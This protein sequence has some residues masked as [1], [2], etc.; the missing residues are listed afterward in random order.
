MLIINVFGC[1]RR[2]LDSQINYNK[3]E[4]CSEWSMFCVV[5]KNITWLIINNYLK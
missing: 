5:Y 4:K 1:T 2:K 3:A